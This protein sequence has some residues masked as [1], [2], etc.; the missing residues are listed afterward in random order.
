M[1]QSRCESESRKD[2]TR[3]EL[4]GC[5]KAELDIVDARKVGAL[6]AVYGGQKRTKSTA[7]DM[8]MRSQRGDLRI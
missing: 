3:A 2:W 6:L 4:L 7:R 8:R 1:G 5:V